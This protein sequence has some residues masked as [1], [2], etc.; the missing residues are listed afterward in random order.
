MD[1]TILFTMNRNSLRQI[2]RVEGFELSAS[3]PA[4][5]VLGVGCTSRTWLVQPIAPTNESERDIG[6]ST[7]GAAV[8]PATPALVF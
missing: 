3:E 5:H 6:E 4:S 7:S 1:D 2:A 8:S